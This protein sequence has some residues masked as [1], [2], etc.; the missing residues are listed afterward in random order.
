MLLWSIYQFETRESFKSTNIIM[1]PPWCGSWC[2]GG[3]SSSAS[4]WADGPSRCPPQCC[5]EGH[6]WSERCPP[7]PGGL[8]P[9]TAHA[10]ACPPP[11]A[12]S[13]TPSAP[14]RIVTPLASSFTQNR[15]IDWCHLCSF[16]LH[17]NRSIGVTS[18]ASSVTQIDRLVSPHPASPQLS[19][20]LTLWKRAQYYCIW[21]GPISPHL[22][23][24]FGTFW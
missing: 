23:N 18:L 12:T 13:T 5:G 4:V 7:P 11:P 16:K 9:S 8:G 3:A 22:S 17:T 10:S 6:G 2:A 24:C 1:I 19:C 20:F 15:S 21:H 14:L